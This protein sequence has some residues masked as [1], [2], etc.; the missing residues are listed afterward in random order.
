MAEVL[1]QSEIDAL[2][3]ALNTGEVDTSEMVSNEKKVR[4]Y[5]FTRPSKFSREHLKTLQIIYD[6]YSRTLSSY[7]SGYL[8]MSTHITVDSVEALTYKEFSGGL[9]NP[10]L[11]VFL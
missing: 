7:F 3:S 4:D 8:R 2:L 6:N 5:D 9:S 1:S 11:L 10:L